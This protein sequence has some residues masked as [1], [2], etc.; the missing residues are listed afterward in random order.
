MIYSITSVLIETIVAANADGRQ[1][2]VQSKPPTKTRV[3]EM[4]QKER[5]SC[6]CEISRAEQTKKKHNFPLGAVVSWR[7]V[8]PLS[9]LPEFHYYY[10]RYVLCP[11]MISCNL[12]RTFILLHLRFISSDCWAL[13]SQERLVEVDIVSQFFFWSKH[14]CR[15]AQQESERE[16]DY[17]IILHQ[18]R[19]HFFL[20]RVGSDFHT[21]LACLTRDLNE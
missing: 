17:C 1:L 9:L 16:R 19:A 18:L 11:F 14:A 13:A 10:S 4:T 6:V 5:L 3:N 7:T 2:C 20:R 21:T 15:P 12:L 8:G